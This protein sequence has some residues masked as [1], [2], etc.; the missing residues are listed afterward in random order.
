[1]KKKLKAQNST[2]NS[3]TNSKHIAVFVVAD[4]IRIKPS[5]YFKKHAGITQKDKNVST[6]YLDTTTSIP[7]QG[8]YKL[9]A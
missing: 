3:T 9:I 8:S 2:K 6:N 5:K 1:M 4:V 7:Q